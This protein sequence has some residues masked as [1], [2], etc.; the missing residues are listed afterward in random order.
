M[1]K[2]EKENF[3]L[4]KKKLVLVQIREKTK[5]VIEFNKA[6]AASIKSIAVKKK[7]EIK[8]T[9]DLCLENY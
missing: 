3:K 5:M 4:L 9:L 8:A 2:P 1:Q 6:E 7:S